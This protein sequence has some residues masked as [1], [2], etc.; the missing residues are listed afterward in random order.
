MAKVLSSSNG[1]IMTTK[2]NTPPKGRP[3]IGP[4]S[5]TGSRP[6]ATKPGGQKLTTFNF[7]AGTMPNK[8]PGSTASRGVFSGKP[9]GKMPKASGAMPKF[10]GRGR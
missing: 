2:N 4:G 3:N 5:T 8:Q 9:A 7:N 6:G 1:K 10:G